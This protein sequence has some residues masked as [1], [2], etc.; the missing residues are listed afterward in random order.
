MY[1]TDDYLSGTYDSCKDVIVPSTGH[2]AIT[3]MCGSEGDQGCSS[4]KLYKVLGNVKSAYV[5]FQI[6]YKTEASEKINSRF[7]PINPK[8]VRCN[9]SVD[10]TK[11]PCS[12]IDCSLSYIPQPDEKSISDE[13]ENLILGLHK[14]TAFSILLFLIGSGIFLIVSNS[15][16]EGE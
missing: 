3:M 7:I 9:E 6:N 15:S 11:P 8:V 5:P 12:C 14:H 1:V 2:R 4:K 13:S 10:G 16:N